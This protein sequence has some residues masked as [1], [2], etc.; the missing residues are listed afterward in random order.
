MFWKSNVESSHSPPNQGE[1]SGTGSSPTQE[2][3]RLFSEKLNPVY[4]FPRQPGLSRRFSKVAAIS[5]L[6]CTTVLIGGHLSTQIV[7]AQVPISGLQTSDS[8]AL[9]SLKTV[10]VPKPSNWSE[11]VKNETAAIQL[12]K[13]LFWDI[14][15]GSDGFTACASCH[16]N[17]GADARSRNQGHP[18]KGSSTVSRG[19]NYAWQPGDFPLHLLSDIRNRNSSLIRDTPDILGSQGVFRTQF[20][21]V[22]PGEPKDDETP[23]PD[24]VFNVGG[25]N[26]RQATDRNT[27]TNINAV[28]NHRNFWD[29]RAQNLFNGVNPFGLR[30]PNARVLQATGASSAQLVRVT[31]DNASL[32][33]QAVGPVLS[34]VEP[35]AAGRTFPDLSKRLSRVVPLGQ[36]VVA[37]N[38][39]VLGSLA[40]STSSTQAKGL[41]TRY[42]DMIRNAFQDRWWNANVIVTVN[43]DNSISLR[44]ANGQT[45]LAANEYT[46]LDYNFSLFFGLAVQAYEST[47]VSNDSKFDRFAEG[48]TSLSSSEANGKKLFE[49]KAKCI[50]C[51]K[52]AEFTGA[53]VRNVRNER[54]ERMIVGDGGEAIYDN[55]FYNIGVRPTAVDLGVGGSDPF[56][57]SLSES[58][59]ARQGKFQQLLGESPNISVSANDRITKDGAFKTPSLRNVELTPPYFHTGSQKNLTEVVQFYNRGGDRRGGTDGLFASGQSCSRE[60]SVKSTSFSSALNWR[61]VNETNQNLN[62]YWLD[63]S[64]R[65]IYYGTFLPG[66]EWRGL[67]YKTHPWLITDSSNR[68]VFL[69]PDAAEQTDI[70]IRGVGPQQCDTTGFG[71]NCSNLDADIERL[72]LSDSE[73]NDIVNFLRTLTDDRVRFHRAPFDHPELPIPNGHVG[74]TNSITDRG[75]RTATD[76]ALLLAAVGQ[77]GYSVAPPIFLEAPNS[78]LSPT[79]PPQYETWT[80]C[81]SEGQSCS[82]SGTK[83][84]RYGTD[85][86]YIIRTAS[87][88]SVCNNDAFGSDPVPGKLKQCQVS[89]AVVSGG[90]TGSTIWSFC[91]AENGFC[92]FSGSATVRYGANGQ[93]ATRTLTNGTACTNSV[94]GDPAPGAQKTCEVGVQTTQPPNWV[95]CSNEG[96]RCTFS[97][98]T[99]VRYGANGT[100]SSQTFTNG[101]DCNNINFGDPVPGAS[102]RCEYNANQVAAIPWTFCANEN[103]TCSFS[104]T[105]T[106]RYG[107]NGQYR[108]NVFTSST[109]CSNTAF[110]GDPALGVRKTC[111]YQ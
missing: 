59:L 70:R 14:Q 99:Q 77:G 12:G 75:N 44:A 31:L 26:V 19:L 72:G 20:T 9:A 43:P 1:D 6:V 63:Y 84:V 4:W 8:N 55:G 85:G 22:T 110:G 11:F 87:N 27:P 32:A 67:S 104:G 36:Q 61:F 42:P 28:F 47:L 101:V 105:R 39:S 81:A 71:N 7:Q 46:M 10:S 50:S 88:G 40:N 97:G 33:S 58:E 53:S 92:A 106:V 62:L 23:I 30:D 65:R 96:G 38:D 64:G 69:V 13:A 68:C 86:T 82:F 34:T 29:G 54:L 48:R 103:Q 16:F 2:L 78:V 98:T 21:G 100:Y 41:R 79:T 49:D 80:T 102:K 5:I 94:F 73:V 3:L 52:G 56:G 45:N 111:E 51:H 90:G 15:Q 93:Y 74:S 83:R 91:A 24:P 107:A 60:G 37:F 18:I 109:A 108:T 25:I 17:A 66:R 57:N 89:D 95:F 35:S 76:S